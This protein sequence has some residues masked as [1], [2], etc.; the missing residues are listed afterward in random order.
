VFCCFASGH[1]LNPPLF[2]SWTRILGAV[3]GSVLWLAEHNANMASNLRRAAM[4]RGVAAERLVFAAKI[5]YAEHLARYG[6]ADLCLDSFP[7]NGGTTTS[8]ALWAGLPV[9]ALAG[10]SFS[11][12][13]SGSLLNALGLPELIVT[14]ATDYEHLAVALA[15]DRGVLDALRKRVAANPSRISLFDGARFSRD[16]EKAYSKIWQRYLQRRAPANLAVEPAT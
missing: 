9:L 13:M 3:P 8:D 1:K 7:F 10:R 16:L 14:S 6:L 4:E 2:D 15:G 5:G 12:R 11:G